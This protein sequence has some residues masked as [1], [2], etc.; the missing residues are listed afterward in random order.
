MLQD[1]D[2][3]V[4]KVKSLDPYLKVKK[5]LFG[6]DILD[7]LQ[8]MRSEVGDCQNVR[9][10]HLLAVRAMNSC[11]NGLQS[12]ASN[13]VIDL[14]V[15]LPTAG[16]YSFDAHSITLNDNVWL[17]DRMLN[18]FQ[19]LNEDATYDFTSVAGNIPTR[20]ALHFGALVTNVRD[21]AS[22]T[23]V[24]SFDSTVNISVSEDIASGRV[25]IL[26]MAGRTVQTAAINSSRTVV[27][28][29][30]VTGIYLVRVETQKG[31]ETHRLLLR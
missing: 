24:Y 5:H 2:L 25:T 29:D 20:F 26:D 9:D 12:V 4:S 13:P 14:G 17:E 3:L 10:F 31:A 8:A 30:L 22:F 27:A 11:I 7:S 15:K 21:R 18:I 23:S 16:D 6:Y 19:H 1:F 28:T